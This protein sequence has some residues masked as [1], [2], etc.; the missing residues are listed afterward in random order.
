MNV[1]HC[2]PSVVNNQKLVIQLDLYQKIDQD[3]KKN[4][5]IYP[6][7]FKVWLHY[8]TARP[9][10]VYAAHIKY[11]YR[12][13]FISQIIETINIIIYTTYLVTV[14]SIS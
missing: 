7:K 5:G 1:V 4:A 3:T 14:W 9:I 2:R 6:R 13:I 8:N 11:Y 10:A 12:N